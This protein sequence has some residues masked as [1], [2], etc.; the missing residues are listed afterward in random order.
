MTDKDNRL[1]TGFGK[2]VDDDQNSSPPAPRGPVLMQDVH[3]SRSWPTSTASAS[4]S[5][6][7]TPRAPAPSA[8]SR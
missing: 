6:W 3:L 1:T 4:P 5:G 7:C 8:T 2:P